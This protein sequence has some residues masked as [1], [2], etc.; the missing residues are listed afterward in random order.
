MELATKLDIEKIR[1]DIERVRG[2]ILVLKWM[3]GVSIAGI[4][5]LILKSFF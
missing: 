1:V 2:E 5:S 4:L 3:L